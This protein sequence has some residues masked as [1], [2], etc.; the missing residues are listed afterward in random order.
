MIR[1]DRA[2]GIGQLDKELFEGWL[3]GPFGT[4]MRIPVTDDRAAGVVQIDKEAF[5]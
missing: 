2:V 3:V 1:G 5:V 4:S